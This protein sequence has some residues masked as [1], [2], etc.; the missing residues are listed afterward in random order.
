MNIG[1][2]ACIGVGAMGEA[3]V[4]GI[5]SA[6][7]LPA[8]A[9]SVADADA[10]RLRQVI[11]KHGVHGG[12]NEEV[13]AGAD[14]VIVAVK[15]QFVAHVLQQI[16]PVLKPDVLVISI[17]AGVTLASLQTHL[18]QGTAI[19]RAMPNT[20]ALVQAGAT[21]L[22]AADGVSEKQLDV[23]L[24]LFGVIGKATVVDEAMM[25]AVT[26]LSGS[27]PAYVYLF[28]EALADGAVRVGLPRDTALQLAA[29]TVLG[30]AQMVLETGLHPGTL[31]DMVTSPAGTTIAGVAALEDRGFRA[32]CIRAVEAATLRSVE[33]G[34]PHKGESD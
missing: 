3:L 28:I 13:S 6:K 33:L 31:K 16:G 23:A 12:S 14:V 11:E 2:I 21:A 24:R 19:I 32:A 30:A 5:L 20:P 17:A 1:R 18:P 29:Q 4:A 10:R 15:P 9:V 22:A 7:L 25:D 26:G 8:T 27:G 34:R